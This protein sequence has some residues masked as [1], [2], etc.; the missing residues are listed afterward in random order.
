MIKYLLILFIVLMPVISDAQSNS[1]E[2]PD[3]VITGSK[4]VSIPTIKKNSPEAIVKLES[5]NFDI[6]V[7]S[8]DVPF[9]KLSA[10]SI[11]KNVQDSIPSI[12]SGMLRIGAG[13]Y[14]QPTGDFF[15]NTGVEH[16]LVN[17]HLYGKNIKDYEDYSRHNISGAEGKL[18]FFISPKSILFPGSK[19]DLSGKYVKNNY[20]LFGSNNPGQLRQNDLN[21]THLSFENNYSNNF[22]YSI[23]FYASKLEM[24]SD[25]LQE[26]NMNI[27]PQFI[28]KWNGFRIMTSASIITYK[29]YSDFSAYNSFQKYFG[30][31]EMNP[32]KHFSVKAGGE[33]I[34]FEWSNYFK[35]FVEVSYQLNNQFV[36]SGTFKPFMKYYTH[37]DF[38]NINPY[39]IPSNI[40]SVTENHKLF[41]EFSFLYNFAKN[42]EVKTFVSYD[43]IDSLIFIDDY[44]NYKEPK[45]ETISDVWNL[46]TGLNAK[47]KTGMLGNFYLAIQWQSLFNKEKIYLPA[48]PELEV[49]FIHN[50]S[51]SKT[52]GLVTKLEF[53]DGL[54]YQIS[55]KT[56]SPSQ[57]N[58]GI[59]VNYFIT[60]GFN[61]FVNINNL[62]NKK[63]SDFEYYR[64]K[65]LDVLIGFEYQ[66]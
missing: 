10:P 31:V 45:V 62:T 44:K 42:L 3:F 39:Y 6:N 17:L 12:R 58:L 57:L 51:I 46:K 38:I 16:V 30:S 33:Y 41:S 4:S 14:I 49:N 55:S 63:Y 56:K 48:V 52:I 50:L 28:L 2:L 8:E 53:V 18:D 35:P 29:V 65:P 43:N 54:H 7:I 47:L 27:E 19:F 64:H 11:L 22:N 24:K 15:L 13:Y 34:N 26:I 40:N 20:R 60:S 66:W 23:N 25:S 61:L 37:T 32:M 1:I 9:P 59:E 21:G 36:F 5:E